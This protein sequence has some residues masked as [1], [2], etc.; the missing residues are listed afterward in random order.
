MVKPVDVSL[1][2]SLPEGIEVG[3]AKLTPDGELILRDKNGKDIT[4]L[5]ME[6]KVGYKR[7]NKNHK[8]QVSQSASSQMLS[9]SGIKEL[10]KYDSIFFIDT[11][12]PKKNDQIYISAFVSVELEQ[13]ENEIKMI[14]PEERIH[15]YEFHNVQVK[16]ELLGIYKLIQDIK[17]STSDLDQ[18]NFLIV[19]DTEENLLKD[20]NNKT[21]PLYKNHYLPPNFSLAYASTDTGAWVTN[22]PIRFCDKQAN[23]YY[24]S[25]KKENLPK[26]PL[27]PL[28]EEPNIQ[29]RYMSKNGL[30]I[31]NPALK[32][33]KIPE[34][35]S[36]KL[37]RKKKD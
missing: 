19:T 21:I 6:R 4:P 37:Y 8:I 34:G 26:T 14:C 10:L 27:R 28:E 15:F 13:V 20:I 22:K 29:F 2:F 5:T 25:L 24:D 32:A 11:N 17:S 31:V 36:I 35:T 30:E 16:P 33:Q 3:E 7:E 1:E 12:N 23:I 9:F 18:K